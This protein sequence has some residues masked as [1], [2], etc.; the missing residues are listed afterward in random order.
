MRA[1]LAGLALSLEGK[2]RLTLEL[3]EDFREE[4]D[5]LGEQELEVTIKGTT[6]FSGG[7]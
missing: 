2:Q 1:R 4:Y 7:A 5:R 6:G 3:V